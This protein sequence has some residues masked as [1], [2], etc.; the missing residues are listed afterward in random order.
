[1]HLALFSYNYAPEPTGIPYYNTRMCAWLVRRLGWRVTVHT[2]IPHYP[3]WQVPAEYAGR[4]FRAGRGD[5]VIDGVEVQRV[6]HY[7]P[8]PPVGGMKRMRLDASWLLAT[9]WRS[10]FQRKRPDALVF[11]APPFLG[12]LLALW[13][14][15]RWRVPVIWHVQDL[16]VDAALDLGML[17]GWMGRTLLAIERFILARVDLVTTISPGMARRLR[18]KGPCRRFAMFPNW[19]DT[20]AMVPHVGVNGY[21]AEWGVTAGEL[22]V[23]YSG[24]LG[25]KQ[26]VDTLVAAA[27]LLRDEPRIRVVIAGAGAERDELAAAVQARGLTRVLVLSLAP[28]E[29]LAEFLSAADVHVITQ[30]RAAADAVMP[31]K[32][33]NIMAVARPVVVTAEPGTDLCRTVVDEAHCGVAVMPEEPEALAEALRGMLVAERD[34]LG[35]AGRRFVCERL[36]ID[37]VLTGFARRVRGLVN[38]G[39]R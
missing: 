10:L 31:S 20:S 39:R 24:N 25:K 4:D 30:K 37:P 26:G 5:E 14:R 36:D 33:L 34:V 19:A 22:V 13:L 9:A 6:P 29:R 7:V 32:L 15:F 35:A 21:R 23:M 38:H 28:A 8:G 18:A 3:W 12:G 17:P 1:M 27:A 2:G 11:I 16:Q